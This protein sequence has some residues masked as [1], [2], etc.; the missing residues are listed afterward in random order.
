MSLPKELQ[1]QSFV[2]RLLRAILIRVIMPLYRPFLLIYLNNSRNFT[3]DKI[4]IKVFKGVFHPGFFFSTRLYLKFIS[5]LDIKN[6]TF[7]DLGAGSGIIGF[8]AEKRGAIVT[9][10][11]INPVV[12]KGL[13][14]NKKQLS[15]TINIIESNLF[16]KIHSYF[17][18]IIIS[19]PYYPKNPINDAEKAWFCGENFEYFSN[20]FQQLK[21]QLD[22]GAKAFM[23]LSQDC[24]IERIQQLAIEKNLKLELKF[25]K[26]KMLEWNYIFCVSKE[27]RS[28]F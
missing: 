15:S 12:I 13:E 16:E 3:Y 28:E 20:L 24:D 8:V 14:F 19:P 11:D 25:R 27:P 22:H 5:E 23:I 4:K 1:E 10:T 18:I 7:L 2:F 26:R 17:E 6:K 9:S 21:N